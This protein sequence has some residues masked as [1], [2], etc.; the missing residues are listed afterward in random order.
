[1][2][3][4]LFDAWR[5]GSGSDTQ[6]RARAAIVRGQSL[7]NTRAFDIRGVKGLN[8]V[9][10]EPVVHATCAACHNV[11]G[12]GN[13]SQGLRFDVGVSDASRRTAPVPLYVL[14]DH[15]SGATV[16]VT[17]PGRALVSGRW[18]D[19]GRFKVP[20]LRG[21]AAHPPYLHDG[22]AASLAD[23][24]DYFDARF[25]IGLTPNEKADLVA[26]LAAL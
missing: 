14:R 21:L 23:V 26:F 2:V 20:S 1:M 12:V 16:Q 15:A 13:N 7:F 22:S 9:L 6:S 4:T 11:P 24:V 8:D 18:E 17:D 5:N 10:N 25:Q 3:F 19:V